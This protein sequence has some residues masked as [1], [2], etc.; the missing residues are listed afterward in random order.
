MQSKTGFLMCPGG[1]PLHIHVDERHSSRLEGFMTIS[2]F[3]YD[4]KLG[5]I[6]GANASV[7]CNPPVLTG[8]RGEKWSKI[9][10]GG[11]GPNALEGVSWL[12]LGN[13]LHF[14]L[15]WFT[16]KSPLNC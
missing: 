6:R 14:C 7:F 2:R 4:T 12:F 1:G 13:I 16:E 8:L 15:L 9:Q 11:S 3:T 5:P 10:V